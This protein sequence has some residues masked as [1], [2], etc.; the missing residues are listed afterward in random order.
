M[1]IRDR[2]KPTD[3][4]CESAERKATTVHIHHRHCITFITSHAEGDEWLC[5]R[6]V[7]RYI[8][9][10]DCKQLPGANSSLIVSHQTSSV[11]SLATG[12]EVI[13]LR[14]VKGQGRWERYA[15]YWA[16]LVIA[17]THCWLITEIAC[18]NLLQWFFFLGKWRV[19]EEIKNA[20]ASDGGRWLCAFSFT[21]I[22]RQ[23]AA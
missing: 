20:T 9:R 21:E 4:D 1:C 10:Y 19:A 11:I 23:T 12:D 5:F 13:K 2:T 22:V 8:F 6:H 14:K 17:G 7:I 3:L 16:F 18:K 15:L